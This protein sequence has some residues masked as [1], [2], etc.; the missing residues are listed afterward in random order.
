MYQIDSL[1]ASLSSKIPSTSKD[2]TGRTF[3][4]VKW[5]LLMSPGDSVIKANQN[6]Y[7]CRDILY[8]SFYMTRRKAAKSSLKNSKFGIIMLLSDIIII[9]FCL[10]L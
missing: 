6:S 9:Y 8:D 3:T 2:S 1:V 7:K 10:K 5:S 4:R